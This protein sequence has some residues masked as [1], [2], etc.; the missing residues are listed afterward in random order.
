MIPS[1]IIRPT[2][3]TIYNLGHTIIQ[4]L[5]HQTYR[6]KIIRYNGA[7]IIKLL[8]FVSNNTTHIPPNLQLPWGDA[9]IPPHLIYTGKSPLKISLDIGGSGIKQFNSAYFGINGNIKYRPVSC[10]CR[11]CINNTFS[12]CCNQSLFSGRYTNITNVPDHPSY[13]D[14]RD[15]NVN[16]NVS[17]SNHNNR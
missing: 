7:D 2:E 3:R 4:R 5:F 12:R 14:L 9:I 17:N 11:Q 16:Q 13:S 15:N 10:H 1:R 8:N 6:N